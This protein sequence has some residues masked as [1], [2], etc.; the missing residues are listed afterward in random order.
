V[1]KYCPHRGDRM[2]NLHNI[3]EATIVEDMGKNMCCEKF[4]PVDRLNSPLGQDLFFGPNI[5]ENKWLL[6]SF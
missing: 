5:E 6:L 2:K 3:Q 1:Y 4:H